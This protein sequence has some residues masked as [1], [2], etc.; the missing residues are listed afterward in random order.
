MATY[1]VRT[2]ANG[3]SD[4]AAGT[5]TTT[6]WATFTKAFSTTGFTSGDTVYVEPGVYRETVTALNTSPTTRAFVIGDYDGAI[7]GTKGEVRW[8]GYLTSDDAAG[9]GVSL[10]SMNSRDNITIRGIRMENASRC[11][12]IPSGSINIDVEDCVLINGSQG[13]IAISSGA[14]VATGCN[15]RRCIIHTLQ[16]C[17]LIAP[18]FGG[19]SDWSLNLAIENCVLHSMQQRAIFVGTGTGTLRVASG[20]TITNCTMT[21]PTGIGVAAGRYATNGVTVTNS[22]FYLCATGISAGTTGQVTEDYNRFAMCSTPTTNI[23]TNGAN[24]NLVG[25][26]NID[27]GM[28]FL[29]DYTPR[30]PWYMPYV[31]NVIN[32]D[33]TATGAPTNDV[34]STTRPNPP[35]IGASEQTTLYTSGVAANP[36]GG[37]VG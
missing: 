25:N 22:L 23:A 19:G 12:D 13:T 27:M 6:A 29:F 2:P 37:Y 11:I 36:L 3:G 24:T 17:L 21:A 10:L 14:S 16:D 34:H 4:S 5:S 1:Y 26:L 9:A 20:V 32:G 33:G 8:S 31:A 35:S 30:M 15:I 28:S 7:F 18:N